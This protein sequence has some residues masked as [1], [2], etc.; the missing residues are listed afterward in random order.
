MTRCWLRCGW[1]PASSARRVN[2][3]PEISPHVRFQRRRENPIPTL[4][5][6]LA[7]VYICGFFSACACCSHQ[8]VVCAAA[9]SGIVRV[10]RQLQQ[11]NECGCR[12]GCHRLACEPYEAVGHGHARRKAQKLIAQPVGALQRKADG[13]HRVLCPNRRRGCGGCHSCRCVFGGGA[14]ATNRAAVCPAGC[15]RPVA[16]FWHWYGV[17]G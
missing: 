8:N 1:V 10:H 14:R 4:L 3:W 15:G 2:L 11:G 9:T 5:I 16:S 6:S 17:R 7:C 12:K 13:Q